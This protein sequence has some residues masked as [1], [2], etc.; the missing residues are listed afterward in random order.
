MIDTHCHLTFP[1]LADNLEG[2]LQRAAEAGVSHLITIGTTADESLK[3]Y[4][5]A[6]RYAN[7]ASTAGVHP[8]YEESADNFV[9]ALR[10]LLSDPKVV[11]VG[12][13]GLDYFHDKV[14]PAIQRASFIKQMALADEVGKPVV[15][16]SR[17]SIA[18]CLAVMA[19]FPDVPAVFHCFTGTVAEVRQ[20][21]WRGYYV[22]FT[23]PLTFK[24]SDELRQAA[25]LVP[26][27][28]ILVETD[29]P[30]LS[31]E[32]RR[33][34]RPCEP[35]YVRYTLDTLAKVRGWRVRQ[36]DEITTENAKRLFGWPA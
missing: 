26:Q 3:G 5:L 12:E 21:I 23:G 14:D 35:A 1:Q 18:D 9:P 30:F 13:C 31:P 34:R 8:C 4:D 15:I 7:V 10:D 33:G 22:G 36:A 19:D 17:E 20:I 25:L 11:A 2:V 29:A 16:H 6:R 24:K 27:E 32:P 28:R